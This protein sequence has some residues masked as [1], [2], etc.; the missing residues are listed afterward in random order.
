V[1]APIAEAQLMETFLLNQ[2]TFQTAVATKATCPRWPAGPAPCS[3]RP[4]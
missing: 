2:V 4:G 3:T 1:T